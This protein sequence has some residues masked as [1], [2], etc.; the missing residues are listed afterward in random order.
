VIIEL[1][2]E[3]IVQIV[4]D[5]GSNYKKTCMLVSQKYQI[6][7]QPCL[8]HTM[9][10]MLKSIGE[11]PDHK[12]MIN[13]ARRICR[14]LYN[15]NKLHSMMRATIGRELVRWNTTRFG[16]YYMFLESIYRRKDKFM[17]WMSS[18]GFVESRYSSTD[19]R[20]YA[21]SCLSSLTWWD[22]MQHVLK[23][24]KSLYAFLHFA[25][26]DKIPN[27]SEVLLQFHMCTSEYKSLLCDY[28][29]GLDQYMRVIKPRMGDIQTQP[30]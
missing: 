29:S 24:V 16:T 20:K 23:G 26:Q 5:N 28:P 1:G 18:T 13:G 9:N 25:N 7:W 19:E 22:M 21:H 30:L 3:H 14:W 2:D 11:F 12:A 8:T 27:L 15:H 4:T 10:L 17:A 6:V